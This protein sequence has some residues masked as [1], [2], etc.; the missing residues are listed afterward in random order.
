MGAGGPASELIMFIVAVIVAGTVAGALTYVTNDIAHGINDK[1]SLLA[2]KLRT[3]FAIIND[4]LNIPNSTSTSQYNYTFYI[5]NTGKTQFPF[6]PNAVQVF[7]DGDIVPPSNL[8]FTDINNN[9]I[10]YLNPYEVGKIVVSLSG[11]LTKGSHRIV[12]VLENGERRSLI[13]KI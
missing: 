8:T 10:T 9:T 11:P 6:N 2:D 13:F 12:V 4:P 5:K 3:D 1:G 7:I